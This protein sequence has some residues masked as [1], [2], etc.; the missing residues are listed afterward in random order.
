MIGILG[1]GRVAQ[2][3]GHALSQRGETV[4]LSGRRDEAAQQAATFVGGAATA[5]AVRD[6]VRE[7]ERILVA[8]TD[9]AIPAAAEL[10]RISGMTAGQVLH[11]CGALG[12]SALQ[13][14][15]AVG[16]SA[17]VLHPLQSIADPTPGVDAL[18][19]VTF[20]VTGDVAA[21][22][23]AR[24]LADKLGGR[25]LELEEEALAVYHAGAVMAGNA[26]FATIDAA[27]V[28][29]E[30]AGVPRD[31]G[32]RAIAPLCRTSLSNALEHGPG[33]AA[34]GPVVRGDGETVE[35]HL[36]Q[37]HGFNP[38]VSNLYIGVS[39]GLLEL[40]RRRGLPETEARGIERRLRA[41]APELQ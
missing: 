28:L 17:G 22:E 19:G 12:P 21:L 10:L 4:L 25:A 38:T 41:A 5:V 34:T 3:L 31:E 9:T 36:E 35:L 26:V 15:R 39:M 13:P 32:R 37:L 23:W 40:G 18:A 33:K 27:L 8:V 29:M 16:V 1:T 20:G 2:T 11:T 14:L 30:R 7:T 24:S 6:L